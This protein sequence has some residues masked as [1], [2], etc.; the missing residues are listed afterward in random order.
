MSLQNEIDKLK[1]LQ[2]SFNELSSKVLDTQAVLTELNNG[3][4]EMVDA[5]ATKNVQSS[6]DKTLSAIASD[7][8]SIAQSPIT[9][10]GG[11]MYAEQL[12]Y[13]VGEDAPFWNL[14]E[15]MTSI[16]SN[17]AYVGYNGVLLLRTYKDEL[18][19]KLVGA[20]AG[21][22]YLTCEGDFYTE[23]SI[24]T[25][26]DFD[27]GKIDRWFVIF[28]AHA[29]IDFN[30]TNNKVIEIH[31]GRSIGT[32]KSSIANNVEKI[33]SSYPNS[34]YETLQFSS[35]SKLGTD[36]FLKMDEITGNIIQDT[37][38][39]NIV[40]DCAKINGY[41]IDKTKT[42]NI[43]SFT[44]RNLVQYDVPTLYA[45]PTAEY[46]LVDFPKGTVF[47][48]SLTEVQYAEGNTIIYGA[49]QN[50]RFIKVRG[51]KEFKHNTS[52]KRNKGAII[53]MVHSSVFQKLESI[54]VD[55]LESGKI[56]GTYHGSYNYEFPVLKEIIAPKYK[57]YFDIEYI[58]NIPNLENVV[59]GEMTECFN[60]PCWNPSIV[61]SNPESLARL[62]QNIHNN[63]AS[64]VSDRTGQDPLTFTVS[65]EL[66]DVLLPE[67]E[68][69]F[70]SKNWN[71][72]PAKSV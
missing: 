15:V 27:N 57:K 32:I 8:R 9:I 17:G 13:G 62:Q 58:N 36:I 10:E 1:T 66:R 54:I 63:I 22:A 50:L 18:E 69:L 14:Q 41:I 12:Y 65:Q 60:F 43:N 30:L 19:T 39:K 55:D 5:L 42:K 70:S 72:A 3:K 47:N 25:W 45:Q 33:V 71:I 20:G 31:V 46:I 6:A 64:R 23:D 11:E 28:N 26:N 37:S 48:G 61:L 2:E 49:A 56:I 21:G 53:Y 40:L 67:T 44:F 4:Q 38:V 59:V 52:S 35:T 68:A 51:V 24:H 29:G 16:L 7:V 34:S